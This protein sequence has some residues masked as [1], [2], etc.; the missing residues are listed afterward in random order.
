[1]LQG[2]APPP[3]RVAFARDVE[4]VPRRL[5]G[6]SAA[7]SKG[8]HRHASP[9]LPRALLSGPTAQQPL[10]FVVGTSTGKSYSVPANIQVVH[11]LMKGHH[12]D[13][14]RCCSDRKSSRSSAAS[15]AAAP[16]AYGGGTQE[17]GRPGGPPGKLASN[18]PQ[19]IR[20][21]ERDY[22]SSRKQYRNL[23]QRFDLSAES[24][25]SGGALAAAPISKHERRQITQ[26]LKDVI[27]DM[28]RKV[29]G[30]MCVFVCVCVCVYGWVRVGG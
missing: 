27:V 6:H 17:A 11:H 4:A 28:E 15:L 23:L 30:V 19:I 29:G 16:S 9:V 7:E 14:C 21:L 22:Q 12:P 25:R 18:L 3:T 8:A 20:H 1:V 10:P 5:A 2:F 13:F 26:A 24:D